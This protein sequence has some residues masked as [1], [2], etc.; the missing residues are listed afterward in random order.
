[1]ETSFLIYCFL[2]R[3]LSLLFNCQ[4]FLEIIDSKLKKIVFCFF[5]P[6]K[7]CEY[8]GRTTQGVVSEFQTKDSKPPP[9]N[10]GNL[11]LA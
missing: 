6:G 3:F 5:L 7:Y 4:I 11:H 2:L 1:M 8:R 9:R 10:K